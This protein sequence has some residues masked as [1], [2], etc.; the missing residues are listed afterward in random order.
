MAQSP[1]VHLYWNASGLTAR[2]LA[3]ILGWSESTVRRHARGW[4]AQGLVRKVGTRFVLTTRGV[5]LCLGYVS[6]V[7]RCAS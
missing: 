4:L 5:L 1:F 3:K 6:P 2:A 7:L